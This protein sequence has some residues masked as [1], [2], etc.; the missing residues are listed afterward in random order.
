MR[1]SVCVSACVSACVCLRVSILVSV[2]VSLCLSVSLCKVKGLILCACPS[3]CVSKNEKGPT[4]H[5]SGH[6]LCMS[7]SAGLIFP[8]TFSPLYLQNLVCSWRKLA[9]GSHRWNSASSGCRRVVE[10][11][12]N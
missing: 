2:F 7:L 12:Y 1:V 6:F 3:V 10:N 8:E 5:H 11:K 4:E 9:P